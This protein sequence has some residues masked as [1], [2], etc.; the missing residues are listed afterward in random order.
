MAVLT[1]ATTLRQTCCH[2]SWALDNVLRRKKNRQKKN[3]LTS[4]SIHQ[5]VSRPRRYV[6]LDDVLDNMIEEMKY[7][8][9][10]A[11]RE[12]ISSL[13]GIACAQLFM[14]DYADAI[15][16]YKSALASIEK[17]SEHIRTDRTQKYHIYY[18]LAQIVETVFGVRQVDATNEQPLEPFNGVQP[19][20]AP[21][22]SLEDA[23]SAEER[24]QGL[25]IDP[26]NDRL[27]R[28]QART[29]YDQYIFN[30]KLAIVTS[31]NYRLELVKNCDDIQKV[32]FAVVTIL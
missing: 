14:G 16:T 19:F 18:N 10:G 27:L 17:Y 9:E 4:T 7:E 26:T 20:T 8:A 21:F 1:M 32:I 11:H 23:Q 31:D 12:K 15:A 29:L 6:S 24:L 28:S 25:P 3:E 22:E 5:K 13:A 2:P 30:E